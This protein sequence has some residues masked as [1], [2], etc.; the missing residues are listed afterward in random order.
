VTKGTG[1]GEHVGEHI[2]NLGNFDPQKR[3][4]ESHCLFVCF[5]FLFLQFCDVVLKLAIIHKKI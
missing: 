1:Y 5:K 4:C 3:N 2:G